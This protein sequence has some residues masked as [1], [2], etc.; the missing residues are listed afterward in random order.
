[1][2]TINTDNIRFNL[3]PMAWLADNRV[4]HLLPAEHVR[5]FINLICFAFKLHATTGSDYV[6]GEFPRATAL[7]HVVNLTSEAIDAMVEADLVSR[8]DGDTYRVEFIT[9]QTTNEGLQRRA[10][11]IAQQNQS[12]AATTRANKAAFKDQAERTAR[13]REK[14]AARSANY[15]ER[16]KAA[17][18]DSDEGEESDAVSGVVDQLISGLPDCTECQ[19]RKKLCGEHD[20]SRELVTAGRAWRDEEP[21]W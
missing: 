3:N 12:R 11:V 7:K 5:A 4:Q 14:D 17:D 1:M 6:D 16:Q 10:D 21:D 15:R 9:P 18:A 2:T 20:G 13:R 19:W 8:V